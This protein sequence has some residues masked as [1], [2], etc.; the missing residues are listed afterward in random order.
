MATILIFQGGATQTITSAGK[1][2]SGPITV[3]TY[4]GTVQLA[5]A[6]NLT[7]QTFTVTNGT[8]STAGFAV[9]AGIFS[10]SNSNVR[11]IN[12][13]ASAIVL[14]TTSAPVVFT[15]V[16]NLTFNAG[17]STVTVSFNAGGNQTYN[18][19]QITWYNVIYVNPSSFSYI[20]GQAT[21]FNNLTFPTQ[22]S[23]VLTNNITVNG[24]LTC[25]GASASSRNSIVSNTLGT[26]RTLSV[27][28]LSAT[29]CD[30]RDINLAGT[31]AGSS[32]TRAGNLG[33]NTNINFPAAKTVYWNLAGTQNW[34][35]NAWAASSGGS[36]AVN[37]FPLAQ[38]TA[39]F[40]NA[41]AAGTITFNGSLPNIDASGRTTAVT[42]TT[43]IF[44]F[45]IYGDLKLGTGVTSSSASGALVF[46]KDGS[47][48]ITSNGVQFGCNVTINRPSATVQL[49]DALSLNSAR[50]LT[51]TRGTFDAVTYNVTTG[52]FGNSSTS[53]TLRMGSGTWTLSGTGTV[54][55]CSVAP[56]IVCGIST[57]VISDTSTTARAFDGGNLYYNKLTVGGATGTSTLTITGS[58]TFG[59]LASTKT[60]AHTITLPSSTTTTVGKWSVTGTVGNVV[61]LAPSTAVT[62]YTLSIS[63]PANTGIDYLSI[64]YCTVAT[65][66][67]G[68]FY[69]G[70]NST[71]TAGNTRVIF[72]ATPAARTLYWVGGTG[73][74]SSTTK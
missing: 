47:Q 12:L 10:S 4:G 6:L 55:S 50:T 5:D 32:P 52:L 11:T 64:S 51:L 8:F 65:T 56:T 57:I 35:A 54:W 53:N 23:L 72:T 71:N 36:P 28:S 15:T 37:N 9:T 70:V 20:F 74:W 22:S 38:D 30:F 16:T 24:T 29:D 2:F 66:S 73:N 13:G 41:G 34:T 58:N 21:T 49:A 63:G 46:A 7:G 45:N 68:E 69:V 43:S 33:G 42:F 14:S 26:Q 39:V 19:G 3:D 1:T 67:P 27:N 40:D 25:S 61:T 60:V 59:E 62:A 17:T 48:T 44:S 31:A 18:W